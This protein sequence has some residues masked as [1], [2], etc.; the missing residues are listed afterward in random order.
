M[1][2]GPPGIG[3]S[4]VLGRWA[5]RVDH[6]VVRCLPAFTSLAYRPLSHALGHPLSG[7][8]DDVASDVMSVIGDRALAVED[9]HW[10]DPSTL[11]V[12]GELIGRIPM[13][14]TTRPRPRSVLGRWWTSS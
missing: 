10:A 5:L 12:L 4:T 1:L 9:V 11:A 14:V 13:V 2:V 8:I 6:V 7:T 3:K